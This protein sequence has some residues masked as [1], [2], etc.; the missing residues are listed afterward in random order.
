IDV[1]LS[2]GKFLS[3]TVGEPGT[4]GAGV[5]GMQGCGVRTPSAAAVAAATWGLAGLM[6]MPKGMMFFMEMWS[7]MFAAGWKLVFTI[8]SGVTT[9]TLGAMPIVHPSDA[10]L[11]TCSGIS[12]SPH[13]TDGSSLCKG[14]RLMT[15]RSQGIAA[16][17]AKPGV[18]G[19]SAVDVAG[20]MC[21]NSLPS[22]RLRQ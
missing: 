2:A 13:L 16:R 17:T 9:N 21:R 12:R 4:H 1:L 8:F 11:Q 15:S 18:P 3:R 19:W 5:A 20:Q 10:P 6:H 22:R 14:W 7:M